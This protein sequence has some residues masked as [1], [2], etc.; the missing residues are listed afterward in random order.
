VATAVGNARWCPSSG[1]REASADPMEL[2]QSLAAVLDQLGQHDEAEL[3][4]R[5]RIDGAKALW[6]DDS[7]QAAGGISELG[8]HFHQRG[9]HASTLSAFREAAR[10]QSVALGPDHSYVGNSRMWVGRALAAG[11]QLDIRP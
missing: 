2:M 11:S 1:R 7:W 8:A 9:A 4:L 3:L 6:S 10:I 5:E